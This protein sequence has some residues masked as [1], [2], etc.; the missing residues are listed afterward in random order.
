MEADPDR[1]VLVDEA[2]VDFGAE[3][4][5]PL[6]KEFDNL[7]VVQTF[8]KYRSMAGARLGFAFGSEELVGDLEKIRYSTNPYS[9]NRMTLA[10]GTAAI[11]NTDYDREH[12]GRIAKTREKVAKALRELGFVLTDSLANF[13]FVKPPAGSGRAFYEGLRRRGILIRVYGTE[14][15]RDYVR[16]TIGDEE[17][18]ERFL[19]A[20]KDYLKEA[21]NA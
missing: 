9:V 8:S 19:D 6:L 11:R 13:L 16:V 21:E 4:C 12:A 5:V 7:L 10:A 14:R 1:L 2:Y 18:M 20:V 3:S 15:I 17:Q